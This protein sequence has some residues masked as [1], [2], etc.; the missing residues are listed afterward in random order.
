MKIFRYASALDSSFQNHF[1]DKDEVLGEF[2]VVRYESEDIEEFEKIN[3]YAL[4]DTPFDATRDLSP[5]VQ[6]W[7]FEPSLGE[8]DSR[9]ARYY[10]GARASNF[11]GRRNTKVANG[12]VCKGQH[13]ENTTIF[14]FEIHKIDDEGFKNNLEAVFGSSRVVIFMG[15]TLGTKPEEFAKGIFDAMF[16]RTSLSKSV[17]AVPYI[18]KIVKKIPN[19]SVGVGFGSEDFGGYFFDVF[20]KNS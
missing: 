12:A 19:L 8:P 13:L 7:I 3:F 14:W 10:Q 20:S 9:I 1:Y 6:A 15:T 18:L 2:S 16:Q 5:R 17:Q 11:I 4:L